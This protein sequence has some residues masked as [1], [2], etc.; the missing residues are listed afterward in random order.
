M[1]SNIKTVDFFNLTK[2]MRF[3]EIIKVQSKIIKN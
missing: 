1:I 3:V 2:G